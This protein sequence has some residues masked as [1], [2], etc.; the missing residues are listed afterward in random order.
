[1]PDA[2][3]SPQAERLAQ[4]SAACRRAGLDR[5]VL[6]LSFDC[7]T[8]EDADAALELLPELQRLHMQASFAVPGAQLLAHPGQYREV[9][10]RGG[11]FINHGGLPH[12]ERCEP[13]YRGVT[14]YSDM[15][16]AEVVADM[17]EG[18]RL[19]QEVLGVTPQGFRAPHFGCFQQPDQL[20][21]LY[22]TA[23]ALGYGFC[24]TTLPALGLEQ[25]G[26]I[27]AGEGLFEFPVSGSLHDPL[28]PLDSWNYLAN[29]EAPELREYV[30]K[31]DY[32]RI[33][34]ETVDFF[35]ER[36][37]PG[38]LNYYADP[39]HVRGAKPFSEALAGLARRGVPV[40][41]LHDLAALASGLRG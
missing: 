36:G 12:A 16:P 34:L 10:A 37:L 22:A 18:H 27:Q 33:L 4:H 28:T 7:D 13:L 23:R 35:L 20:A 25:G 31:Q 3:L 24:S 17:R 39:A 38:V 14:F 41:D 26:L 1:M 40:V 19:V 6:V 2:I 21:L 9:L 5:L 30:L 29:H 11:R 15:S 32:C 8:P